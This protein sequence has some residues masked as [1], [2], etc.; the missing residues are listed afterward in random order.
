[1]FLMLWTI[2][3]EAMT[4]FEKFRVKCILFKHKNCL[5]IAVST[6]HHQTPFKPRSNF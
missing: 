5:T 6:S 4:I 3:R 1:M 2:A